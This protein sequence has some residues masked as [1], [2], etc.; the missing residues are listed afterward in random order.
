MGRSAPCG[1]A[2]RPCRSA[3]WRCVA[4]TAGVAAL[5][6][7]ERGAPVIGHRLAEERDGVN[8]CLCLCLANSLQ[9]VAVDSGLVLANR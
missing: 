7:G 4:S 3:Q 9:E 8:L 2:L 1:L 5:E 6:V